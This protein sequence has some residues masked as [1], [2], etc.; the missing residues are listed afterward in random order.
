MLSFAKKKVV[1]RKVVLQEP[2][3]GTGYAKAEISV[4][5]ELVTDA[6]K[7]YDAPFF[8]AVIKNV[9]DVVDAESKQPIAF[10]PEF[11]DDLLKHDWVVAGLQAEYI[12]CGIGAGRGN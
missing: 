2:V 10:T 4:T 5:W 9:E 6:P 8:K 1:K 3:D 7:T 12:R 11:L